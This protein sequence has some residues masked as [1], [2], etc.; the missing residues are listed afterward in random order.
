[1][2]TLRENERSRYAD[3][4]A[5]LEDELTR[6]R[7]EMAQQLQEYQDLMD[8]KVALDLEIAA[9]R[10]MLESEEARWVTGLVLNNFADRYHSSCDTSLTFIKILFGLQIEDHTDA[11]EHVDEYVHQQSDSVQAHSGQGH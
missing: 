8:I 2:E 6:I 7:E 5:A 3:N 11:I 9:Y 1:M 10:K 4:V